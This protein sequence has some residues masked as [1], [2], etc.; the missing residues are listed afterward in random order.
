MILTIL[1]T[2]ACICFGLQMIA[3]A[4]KD[5]TKAI[6]RNYRAKELLR[7]QRDEVYKDFRKALGS[8]SLSANSRD[9]MDS[10]FKERGMD[11]W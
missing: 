9:K 7:G 8:W 1:L 2:G 5:Q 6:E 10:L 3:Q 11:K 4:I